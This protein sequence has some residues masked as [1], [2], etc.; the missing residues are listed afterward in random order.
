MI[1]GTE[2]F[3][4]QMCADPDL[5]EHAGP[6][7]DCLDALDREAEEGSADAAGLFEVLYWVLRH[8]RH[9]VREKFEQCH[10][11]VNLKGRQSGTLRQLTGW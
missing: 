2:M 10:R 9:S 5:A 6:I 11:L 7:R 8:P 4:L 3:F 1:P